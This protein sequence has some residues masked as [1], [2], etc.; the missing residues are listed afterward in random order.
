[1][2]LK[3][4]LRWHNFGAAVEG[5]IL[6]WVEAGFPVFAELKEPESNYRN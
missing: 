3:F 6:S 2:D 1:M 5:K 4:T